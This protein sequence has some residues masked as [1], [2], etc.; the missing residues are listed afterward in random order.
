MPAVKPAIGC[1]KVQSP[2]TINTKLNTNCNHFHFSEAIVYKLMPVSTNNIAVLNFMLTYEGII[3]VSTCILRSH[4]VST[5]IP[6]TI[7]KIADSLIY[8]LF[9]PCFMKWIKVVKVVLKLKK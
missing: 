8:F 4:P 6:S 9:I 1:R 3:L 5:I 2:T 7:K